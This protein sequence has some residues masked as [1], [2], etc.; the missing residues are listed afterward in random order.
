MSVN[1]EDNSCLFQ[2]EDDK[3]Q[4]CKLEVNGMT[5]TSCVELIESSLR[6]LP[7][8]I[9]VLISLITDRVE[10]QFDPDYLTSVQIVVF[11]QTLG[12]GA[13]LVKEE[14]RQISST[15]SATSSNSVQ[16][17]MHEISLTDT[18]TSH[19]KKSE[20]SAIELQIE[21]KMRLYVNATCR[22]ANNSEL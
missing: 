15:E 17:L 6:K 22:S 1:P 21:G 18:E 19:A 12:Y 11:V 16:S 9:R 3:S 7:G 14:L 4:T 8:V 13:S 20:I 10:I 2:I 5:S